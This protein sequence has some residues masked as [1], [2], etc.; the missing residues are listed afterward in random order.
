MFPYLFL[1]L[2]RIGGLFIIINWL[3]IN[4]LSLLTTNHNV[5]L[6][7]KISTSFDRYFK[8]K[9]RLMVDLIGRS[10]QTIRLYMLCSCD[11][12]SFDCYLTKNYRQNTH[13]TS[14]AC[15]WINTNLWIW[16]SQYFYCFEKIMLKKTVKMWKNWIKVSFGLSF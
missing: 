10:L 16:W 8:W 14:L 7:C 1:T 2:N 4:F 12:D 13:E 15:P 9:G 6:R 5:R 3:I 11:S